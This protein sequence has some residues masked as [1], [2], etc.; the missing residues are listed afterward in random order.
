M[1]EA[2]GLSTDISNTLNINLPLTQNEY[3]VG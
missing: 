1:H 3:N 2:D